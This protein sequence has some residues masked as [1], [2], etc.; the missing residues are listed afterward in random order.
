MRPGDLETELR[1][2]L[3]RRAALTPPPTDLV[4]DAALARARTVR[5]RQTGFGAL[6]L[7]LVATTATAVL[8]HPWWRSPAPGD[9]PPV[10][11][12]ERT[13]TGAAP[14]PM[15]P[16][17]PPTAEATPRSS[18]SVAEPLPGTLARDLMAGE[19]LPVDVIVDDHLLTAAGGRVELTGVGGVHEA[20][21]ITDGWLVLSGAPAGLASLWYVTPGET[22]RN[23]LDA[24]D[25]IVVAPAGDRVAWRA[26]ARVHL[27]ALV[28]GRIEALGDTLASTGT[29]PVAFVGKG[30]LLTRKPT[31]AIT[32]SSTVWWPG[33]EDA[34]LWWRVT[35]GVYG[36]LPDGRTVVAQLPGPG[37]ERPCLAL[38]DAYAELEPQ[39]LACDVPMTA[40][41]VG[42]LSPD[43]R[44]LVAERT[45]AESVV[46]DLDTAFGDR[47]P[48]VGAGPRPNGPGAW[49][50]DC[51][52]VYGGAGYLAR[53]RLD[54]VAAGQ[55]D[56][57]E[58]IAVRPG[59]SEQVLA[60]PRL[61]S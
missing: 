33:A 8:A 46:V 31:E 58:R 59:D 25:R 41:A 26:G 27:G 7:L 13:A 32:G 38:L 47:K 22:P 39:A 53:L 19:R 9:T 17:A 2:C 21:R 16:S 40:G 50:D 12:A 30:L 37:G 36:A 56:A 1:A 18:S 44:W 23:L 55:T 3:R 11:A 10:A 24:V 29:L 35:T 43:G 28:R 51:T 48:A 61:A 14:T 5:R 20:Y 54:R 57:V 34:D 42:S 60:V 15:A 45:V 49:T 52:V 4:A 6:G